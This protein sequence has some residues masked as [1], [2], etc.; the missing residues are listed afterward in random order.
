MGTERTIAP[1]PPSTRRTLIFPAVEIE[2]PRWHVPPPRPSERPTVP[3]LVPARSRADLAEHDAIELSASALESAPASSAEAPSPNSSA[4]SLVIRSRASERRTSERRRGERRR[5]ASSSAATARARKALGDVATALATQPR[6]WMG[7]VLARSVAGNVA[8]G[9]VGVALLAGLA[10]GDSPERLIGPPRVART[11]SAERTPLAP[12]MAEPDLAPPPGACMTAGPSRVLAPAAHLAPG[13]NVNVLERGFGVGFAATPAE[14]L[15]VKL[16]GAMLRVADRVRVRAPHAVRHVAVDVMTDEID[17]RVDGDEGRTVVSD[18]A[19][20]PFKI[21]LGGGWIQSV[22][23]D[24]KRRG[25]WPLPGGQARPA[26]GFVNLGKT[27]KA[28]P[29]PTDV[30]A[31]ARDDGGAVVAVRRPSV[32]WLGLVDA[33]LGAEGVLVPLTRQGAALGMPSVA[34]WGGGGAVAWA[35]RPAGGR[36]WTVVVASF[37]PPEPDGKED[38]RVML[39]AIDAG[40]SPSIVALPDGDLLLAYAIGASGS[41]RVVARRLARD[42]EPRG[43]PF[44]VSPEEINAGQPAAAVGADGRGL[45]AFFGAE[46]GR[47]PTVHATP[48]SCDVGL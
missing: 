35:E 1:P 22:A 36:D 18:G 32:L 2:R 20:A 45:V 26:K 10:T 41:H 33:E 29:I 5:A 21:A 3:S 15:G 16:D 40:M 23:D 11:V 44:V 6:A 25:L 24:G 7:V 19:V 34:A 27:P 43:E 13:L 8:V 38:E 4:R 47:A 46:Q 31:A 17:L 28:I 39:R 12:R 14:A 9:I 48:L 42:L 37:A 30:R